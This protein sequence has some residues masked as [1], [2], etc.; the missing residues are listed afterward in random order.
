MRCFNDLSVLRALKLRLTAPATHNRLCTRY[1]ASDRARPR[2]ARLRRA[3]LSSRDYRMT[4]PLE[5]FGHLP[6]NDKQASG[7]PRMPK[8]RSKAVVE[9]PFESH[10]PAR[11]RRIPTIICRPSSASANAWKRMQSDPQSGQSL[12]YFCRHICLA[13]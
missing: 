8:K 4:Y 9:Q 3:W 1:Q 10:R 2:Q 11:L 7:S 6:C 5:R 13:E 12:L